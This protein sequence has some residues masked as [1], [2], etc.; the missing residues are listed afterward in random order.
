MKAKA[1]EKFAENVGASVISAS[2]LDTFAQSL[3]EWPSLRGE[4]HKSGYNGPKSG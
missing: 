2:E 3:I 4:R 1:C